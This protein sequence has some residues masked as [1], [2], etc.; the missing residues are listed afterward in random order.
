M[1]TGCPAVVDPTASM[2]RPLEKREN[3]NDRVLVSKKHVDVGGLTPTL[4]QVVPN[5]QSETKSYLLRS[6]T[7]FCHL[8]AG[9]NP[10]GGQFGPD[11]LQETMQKLFA[12]PPS[13]S[14]S[15]V[16]K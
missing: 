9:P 16:R 11:F 1:T 14:N 8:V 4:E 15:N 6:F 10:N 7:N 5:L 3:S 12:F 13:D 2:S